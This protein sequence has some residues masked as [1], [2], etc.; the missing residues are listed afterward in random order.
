MDVQ[1]HQAFD[2][3]MTYL[4]ALLVLTAPMECDVLGLHLGVIDFAIS[5]VMFK[6]DN[7]VEKQ[8]H[9]VGMALFPAET[10]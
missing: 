4:Q 10:R 8:I 5:G 2:D 6:E 9:N 7:K 3:L 1:W